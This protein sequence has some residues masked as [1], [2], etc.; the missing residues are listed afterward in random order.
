L[1]PGSWNDKGALEAKDTALEMLHMEVVDHEKSDKVIGD[2]TVPM[3]EILRAR[4]HALANAA[5]LTAANNTVV[6]AGGGGEDDTGDGGDGGG[7]GKLKGGD[8]EEEKEGGAANVKSHAEGFFS[9]FVRK[10]RKKS[11]KAKAGGDTRPTV[12]AEGRGELRL[13]M[14]VKKFVSVTALCVPVIA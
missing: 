3:I 12:D 13:G 2:C 1:N 14:Q 10:A 8:G 5:P 6:V 7:G 4:L 11:K 9:L